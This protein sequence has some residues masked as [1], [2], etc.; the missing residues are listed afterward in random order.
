MNPVTL[1][2]YFLCNI[3]ALVPPSAQPA[4]PHFTRSPHPLASALTEIPCSRRL[5]WNSTLVISGIFGIAAGAAPNFVVFCTMIALIGFGVGGN[6]PVD[7]TLFLEFLPGSKQYLLTLLSLWWALGQV[8]ASL[9]S[10]GRV[11]HSI[12]K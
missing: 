9:I 12:R 5:A 6:L 11:R 4:P 7:G 10:V 1:L 8:V 3:P 2:L